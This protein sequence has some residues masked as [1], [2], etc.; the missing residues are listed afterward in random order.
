M[1]AL[2]WLPPA[3]PDWL[4]QVRAVAANPAASLSDWRAL[5]QLRLDFVQ[6][7]RLDKLLARSGAGAPLRL[8]VLS[9]S[10]AEHLLP[11]L[12]VGALRHGMRLAIHLPAYGQYLQQLL[13]P[14][15]PLRKVDAMLFAFDSAHLIGTD[16]DGLS[17]AAAEA[18]LA[19]AVRRLRQTWRLARA[20]APCQLIQ[21]TLLQ[22]S[23]AALGSNEQ[24]WAASPKRLTERINQAL[25][26]A[27]DADGVD[28]LALDDQCA[29][30]GLAA[31]HDPKLWHRAKQQVSP[32]AA[33]L[34]GEL[35][36]RLLAARR[37]GS[38]K[39]LVLDLDNTLWGGVVGDD[40]VA[41]IALGQGD[42]VGEAHLAFQ[43]YAR[44]LAR[45]GV[46]LA[47]CSKNAE[48]NALAPFLHHPEMALGRADIACFVANWDDKA[49]NLRR[50]AA[51]L[52]IGL[53]AL[54]F[55]D[56]NA[57][58]RN[59]VRCALPMVAVPELPDDPA[60]YAACI[61]EAGYFES[62]GLT[63][64]DS[65]RGGQ[66]QENLQR[67]AA[68]AAH[69]DLDGYLESIGMTL[70]WARVDELN[71]ARVV[72]LI[73]KT[74]QFNLCTRRYQADEV[75]ALM[76]APDA[77]LLQLR[78]RDRFGDNGIIA[79]VI[80]LPGAGAA[81]LRLDTWLMSCRVLGRKVEMATLNIVAAE[82]ARRGVRRLLGH[83]RPS[84][85]NALVSEH[86]RKL[87]FA[88]RATAPDG[89]SEWLLELDGYAPRAA[90]MTIKEIPP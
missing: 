35:V 9:S 38:A 6:T 63:G 70:E 55:A 11:G 50:I 49:S 83:Y 48:E 5:A 72:Q 12:R 69:A 27:A 73:N 24:R 90:P 62:L 77:L 1:T 67:Q 53:D 10:S 8:A 20:C 76:A 68:R 82:A 23:P 26:A 45:R 75:R 44:G 25:R 79:V 74:N 57:F 30:H 18:L 78:L 40:G 3:P 37:G 4:E 41:G 34:Y 31:W 28:L 87:G 2:H 58:E 89:G 21:Q 52:N 66:Y 17:D 84:E 7:A 47:V 64:E 51:E 19:E 86:Y 60:L 39:C 29:L 54:V 42:A 65:A 71:L 59:Q 81:E 36:A 85:K 32:Q 22:V 46:I 15:S 33:P 80:G 88:L 61:A 13:E 14:D 43:R 16:T 56:D